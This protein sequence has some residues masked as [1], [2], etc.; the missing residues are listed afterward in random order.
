MVQY[1]AVRRRKE[2]GEDEGR[3]SLLLSLMEF[4]SR[5]EHGQKK[6]DEIY[7][8]AACRQA[9][10]MASRRAD[11]AAAEEEEGEAGLINFRRRR[12]RGTRRE[13]V[14]LLFSPPFLFHCAV[15]PFPLFFCSQQ[16][17]DE[18][19]PKIGGG[20]GGKKMR[21]SFSPFTS[22]RGQVPYK[23]LSRNADQSL[24]SPVLVF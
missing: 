5:I 12:E 13:A 2:G 14:T 4:L 18:G 1:P 16:R 11:S 19:R 24:L 15:L 20:E 22:R 10:R 21:D 7:I 6:A 8:Y 23:R 17:E 9:G 3:L